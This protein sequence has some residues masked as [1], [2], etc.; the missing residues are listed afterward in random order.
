MF[1]GWVVEVEE[2]SAEREEVLELAELEEAS[3]H[4][5]AHIE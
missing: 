5:E 1:V 2:V 3:C 4:L